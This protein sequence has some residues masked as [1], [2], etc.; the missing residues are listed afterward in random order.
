MANASKKEKIL[1][2]AVEIFRKKGKKTTIS[3]IG[4]TAGVTDSI[5]YHY[6]KN[7][8]DLLYYAAGKQVLELTGTLMEHLGGINDPVEKLRKFIWL[9]LHYHD[10]NPNYTTLT[11][12][13]CRS[14]ER[15]F[16]HESFQHFRDWTRVLTGILKD[17]INKGL[18]DSDIPIQVVRDAIFGLLDMESIHILA[19]K[20]VSEAH[21]FLD[22]IMD[23]ILPFLLKQKKADQNESGKPERILSAA[24]SIFAEK[25][26]DKANMADIAFKAGVGEGTIYDYYKNKESLLFSSLGKRL[27]G[28]TDICREI[29]ENNNPLQRL[30]H[31]I[32][33]HF[34]TYL[35]QPEFM[36]VFIFEGLFNKNFY[37]S[38][39]R[40][41]YRNY[42]NAIIS[43][44]DEGKKTGFIRVDVNNRI[45]KNL[46]LGVT[47]HMALRWYFLDNDK[48]IDKFAEINMAISLLVKSISI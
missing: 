4:K 22:E 14:K 29:S 38:D 39:A 44:V 33:N 5:I 1:N 46:F 30:K 16:N 23:L 6:F 7:K 13:E 40:D 18:F 34:F 21:T 47:S 26:Y 9:Q 20:E 27:Q 43:V 8:E 42:T 12:F 25:G 45:F 10:K 17:G 48:Q 19:E 41:S 2:T 36:K 31:I 15:F 37:T 32:Q 11:I 35:N 28:Q 24:E 3:E